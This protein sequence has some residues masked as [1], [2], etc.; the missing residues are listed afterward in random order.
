MQCVPGSYFPLGFGN[1]AESHLH[2]RTARTIPAAHEPC[3]EQTLHLIVHLACSPQSQLR[4]RIAVQTL[5]KNDSD[6]YQTCVRTT[7]SLRG[8]YVP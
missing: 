7:K 2:S 4:G 3:G 8:R 5:V 6:T 1:G